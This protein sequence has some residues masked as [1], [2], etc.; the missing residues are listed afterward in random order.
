MKSKI[1]ETCDGEQEFLLKIY[2]GCEVPIGFYYEDD[3]KVR[4]HQINKL[5]NSSVFPILHRLIDEEV[6]K[7]F[8]VDDYTFSSKLYAGPYKKLV[9]AFSLQDALQLVIKEFEFHNSLNDDFFINI[10]FQT[11]QKFGKIFK[12]GCQ[13]RILTGYERVQDDNENVYYIWYLYIGKEKTIIDSN[14]TLEEENKI[15]GHFLG[16]LWKS[17]TDITFEKKQL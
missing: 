4:W 6:S 9:D 14:F 2:D 5:L 1:F 3:I 8:Y 10:E 15:I 7:Y 11:L 16:Y 12:Y 17:E 13:I